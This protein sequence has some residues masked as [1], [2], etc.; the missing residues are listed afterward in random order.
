MGELSE[1]KKRCSTC[2]RFPFCNN[3]SDPKGCCEEWIR[4]DIQKDIPKKPESNVVLIRFIKIGKKKACFDRYK[5]ITKVDFEY[6]K[7]EIVPFL[8]QG[9]DFELRENAKGDIEIIVV[10][11]FIK[12]KQGK[13]RI[14]K[15]DHNE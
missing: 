8:K 14:L 6:L 13:I 5:E 2:G 12:I 3:S 9:A 15:G 4:R 11:G 1:V 7:S 10:L